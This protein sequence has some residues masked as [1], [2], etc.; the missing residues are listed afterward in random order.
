LRHPENDVFER[1]GTSKRLDE[2]IKYNY[3]ILPFCAQN[4][5]FDAEKPL[6]GGASQPTVSEVSIR[7]TNLNF[8]IHA[9]CDNVSA[10]LWLF[11]YIEDFRDAVNFGYGTDHVVAC[12][13]GGFRLQDKTRCWRSGN[14]GY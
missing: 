13:I 12:S 9:I 5:Y 3:S 1:F 7:M 14:H 2:I 8:P 11:E 4:V 6:G 10:T